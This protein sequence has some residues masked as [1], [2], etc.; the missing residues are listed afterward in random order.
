MK[1]Q[2]K[3]KKMLFVCFLF[4][5]LA[6]NDFKMSTEFH[7]LASNAKEA[8]ELARAYMPEKK[9][10]YITKVIDPDTLAN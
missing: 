6:G 5:E 4:E 10:F 1:E 2:S 7:L 3:P 9:D 8:E